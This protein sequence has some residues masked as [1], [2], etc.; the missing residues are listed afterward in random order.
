MVE[1]IYVVRQPVMDSN[2]QLLAY[3]LTFRDSMIVNSIVK[4]P[5]EYGRMVLNVL[6]TEPF[7]TF[8][9]QKPAFLKIDPEF[10]SDEFS[11][12]FPTEVI[13]EIDAQQFN[14]EVQQQ[15]QQLKQRGHKLALENIDFPTIL[16]T[17]QGLFDYVKIDTYLYDDN[18]LKKIALIFGKLGIQTV[19][20]RVNTM[21]EFQQLS[22]Y[23]FGSFQGSF[24]FE[25]VVLKGKALNPAKASILELLNLLD[26]NSPVDPIEAIFKRHVDLSFKLLSL[27]NSAAFSLKTTISSIRQ[28]IT[29]LG[30]G[31]IKKWASVLLF[32]SG[33]NDLRSDPFFEMITI[34]ALR[35]EKIASSVNYFD[36]IS[37]RAYFAGMISGFDVL[38][39]TTMTEIIDAMRLDDIFKGALIEHTNPLGELLLV[40][41]A[42]EEDNLPLLTEYAQ[43]I[44]TTLEHLMG[45]SSDA[46]HAFDQSRESY[47]LA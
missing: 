2:K 42:L 17:W 27:I 29:L 21:E 8:S 38:L 4:T 3:R 32:A 9:P 35:M 46:I 25:P 22:S 11:T 15:C 36:T 19:A 24:M 40:A 33:S 18:D 26:K 39:E 10:F 7:S 1:N 30:Y 34:R 47:N 28:A 13:F 41:R 16:P 31:A 12:A 45:T 44:G 6:S 43:K 5:Q 20:E 23:G 14:D 37:D